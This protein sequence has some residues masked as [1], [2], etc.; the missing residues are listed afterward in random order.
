[1][2]SSVLENQ[3]VTSRPQPVEPRALPVGRD[4][5]GSAVFLHG[6]ILC[7]LPRPLHL[8]IC[9]LGGTWS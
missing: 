4:W 6:P 5:K 3:P 8:V 7:G 1:M 9:N 2:L